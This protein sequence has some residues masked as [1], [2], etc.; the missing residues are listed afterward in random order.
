MCVCS[1]L[2]VCFYFLLR[3]FWVYTIEESLKYAGCALASIFEWLW[4]NQAICLAK[5]SSFDSC[6]HS[7]TFVTERTAMKTVYFMHSLLKREQRE[8]FSFIWLGCQ[9]WVRP[10]KLTGVK[11]SDG[12]KLV[13]WDQFRAVDNSPKSLLNASSI[14]WPELVKLSH[15]VNKVTRD[16]PETNQVANCVS[17]LSNTFNSA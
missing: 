1:V 2:C 4:V 13:R 14:F 11:L 9:L 12:G 16:V 7:Y 5:K 6:V 15:L 8:E 3:L 10:H 17:F